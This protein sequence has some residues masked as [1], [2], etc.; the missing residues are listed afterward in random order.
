MT[1]GMSLR[2]GGIYFCLA[3]E[4]NEQLRPIIHSLQYIGTEGDA[5]TGGEGDLRY[6]FRCVG[7]EDSMEFL[8]GQLDLVSDLPSLVT[9]LQEW[10][11]ISEIR[12]RY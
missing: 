9:A 12:G 4:D 3:Y 5:L 11:R 1:D 10:Q 6:V 2:A 8:E 7:S